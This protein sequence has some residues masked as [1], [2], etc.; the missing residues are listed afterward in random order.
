[1]TPAAAMLIAIIVIGGFVLA[2]ALVFV[3]S[4]VLHTIGGKNNGSR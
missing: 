2:G 1:M 4:L 3:G